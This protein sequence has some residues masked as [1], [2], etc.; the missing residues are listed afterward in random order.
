MPETSLFPIECLSSAYHGFTLKI[1]IA[2]DPFTSI[3]ILSNKMSDCGAERHKRHVFNH[4]VS[5]NQCWFLL[6]SLSDCMALAFPPMVFHFKA[7]CLHV[8]TKTQ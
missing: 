8:N 1:G 3:T 7:L 4:P 2:L 6:P 5:G